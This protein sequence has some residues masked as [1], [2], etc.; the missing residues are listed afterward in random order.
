MTILTF[1]HIQYLHLMYAEVAWVL[2]SSGTQIQPQE[3]SIQTTFQTIF[4]FL[5]TMITY[6]LI[7]TI[8]YRTL[9]FIFTNNF[10]ITQLKQYN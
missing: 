8:L 2:V 3:Y 6:I 10:F 7:F 5:V 1:Q 9:F 4:P